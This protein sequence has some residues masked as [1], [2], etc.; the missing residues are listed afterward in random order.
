MVHMRYL[1]AIP[2]D[3]SLPWKTAVISASSAALED[4]DPV[5]LVNEPISSNDVQMDIHMDIVSFGERPV[6]RDEVLQWARK[7]SYRAAT[8]RELLAIPRNISHFFR[9][10]GYFEHSIAPDQRKEFYREPEVFNTPYREKDAQVVCLQLLNIC[11]HDHL[12]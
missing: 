6:T 8:P 1:T 4:D 7:N 3:P 9:I 5:F 10:L 11:G 12:L 2:F